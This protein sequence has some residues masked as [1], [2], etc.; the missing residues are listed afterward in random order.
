MTEGTVTRWLKQE[1]DE[2]QAAEPLLE[3]STDK[4]DTEIPS[5]AA[6]VLT[7]INVREDETVD[8][9]TELAIIGGAESSSAAPQQGQPQRAEPRQE[10]SREEEPPA[11]AEEPS[12]ADAKQPPQDGRGNGSSAEAATQLQSGRVD[13]GGSADETAAAAA[14]ATTDGEATRETPSGDGSAYVTPLVRK[15]ATE[16]DVDLSTLSGS[17]VG[18]RIRKQDVLDAARAKQQAPARE[19]A[20]EPQT[21]QAQPV[22]TPA[23]AAAAAA[24]PG[25]NAPAPSP[26]R[27]RTEK[28]SRLRRVIAQRMVESLQV[29][30]QLTTVV[31]VDVTNIARLRQQVKGEFEAREGVRLSFLPFFAIAA[32]GRSSSILPLTRRST[33]T[34][35][36]SPITSGAPW[37]RRRH[38]A[39]PARSRDQ[40]RRGSQPRRP[41]SQD[42]RPRERTRS[43]KVA[44]DECRAAPSPDQHR[45]PRGTV[46]HADPHQPQV[47][48]LGTGAVVK[49]P[50]VVEDPDLAR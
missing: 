9:G 10:E 41:V 40:E 38:R 2:V 37:R 17:G 8:V 50:V 15:L 36:R 22:G 45:Q 3:V 24:G 30:A 26:L 7:R 13:Y 44:P 28:M 16:H 48:I 42:R 14:S 25:A 33:P 27:G 35:A 20:G 46:R 4:V 18:G 32:I 49:R 21:P 39:R 19:S 1:G 6:G 5:P 11:S 29:S 47:A 31:E 12:A 23:N 43:N 34:R